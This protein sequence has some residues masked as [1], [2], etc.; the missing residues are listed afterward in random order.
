MHHFQASRRRYILDNAKKL[1]NYLKIQF[2]EQ[3]CSGKLVWK[4]KK[5]SAEDTLQLT[6]HVP[7]PNFHW[8]AIHG[9]LG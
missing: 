3:K 6:L 8:Y 4:I 2:F 7:S 9:K 5:L 1:K